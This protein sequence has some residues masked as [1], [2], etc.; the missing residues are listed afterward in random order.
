MEKGK[1][2]SGLFIMIGLIFLGLMI[3]K[4]VSNFRSFDRIVTV[5]G[6]SEREVKADKV[7]SC[8][9]RTKG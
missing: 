8:L 7:I 6:L 2:Y 1:F 3:P 4:A 5:K 9:I